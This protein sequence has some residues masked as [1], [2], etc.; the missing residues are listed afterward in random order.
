MRD[1]K[2]IC[3]GLVI[4]ALLVVSGLSNQSMAS[5]PE[6]IWPTYHG[7]M[8]RKGLNRNSTDITNPASLN[9]IWVFPRA[10]TEI[11]K[12]E[13]KYIVDN[14]NDL[15]S[16]TDDWNADHS[17][18]AWGN[19]VSS[20]TGVA[21]EDPPYSYLWALATNKSATVKAQW[22]FPPEIKS[23][24]FT[25][26][27]WVP[28]A[29]T[30]DPNN[31]QPVEYSYTRN[32]IYTVHDAQGSV[33]VAFDQTK[34]GSWQQLSTTAFDFSGSGKLYI[35]LTNKTGDT[36]ADVNSGKIRVA[37]DAIKF[38]PA[39]GQQIYSS[40]A[41]AQVFYNW[42]KVVT[43]TNGKQTTYQWSGD[44]PVVFT[45]TIEQPFMRSSGAMN[46]GAVYCINSLT[47]SN[48]DFGTN[49]DDIFTDGTRKTLTPKGQELSKELGKPLW[50]Y[51]RNFEA[52][53]D[54]EVDSFLSDAKTNDVLNIEGPVE[55]G[56]YASPAVVQATTN[57][58]KQNTKKFMCVT[59]GMDRQVYALDV[60]QG[61]NLRLLWKGPGMTL[62]EDDISTKWSV[63]PDPVTRTL[64]NDAFGGRFAW[65]LSGSGDSMVWDFGAKNL[66][67][68]RPDNIEGW[69]YNVYVWIPVSKGFENAASGNSLRTKGAS[70]KVTYNGANSA[71]VHVD[72][73]SQSNQG[74][75][76]KLG[77]YFNPEK[78]E[79]DPANSVGTNAY[80]VADAVM[81]VP[82]TIGSF[83]Y[84][85]PAVDIG[86]ALDEYDASDLAT[87]VFA[88]TA[89]Q[90]RLLCFDLSKSGSGNIPGA[91]AVSWVYPEIRTKK[92]ISNPNTNE[93]GDQPSLGQVGASPTYYVSNTGS[94]RVYL[95]TLG[96]VIHCIDPDTG[97]V[98]GT[99]TDTGE[100]DPNS[101]DSTN[102]TGGSVAGFTSSLSVGT[103]GNDISPVP[104]LFTAS[105]QGRV[106]AF[107]P[108]PANNQ[109]RLIAKFT[110]GMPLGAFRYSTPS[111]I[112]V[113]DGTSE[114]MRIWE[115]STDG[116]IYAF[117][118]S[119]TSNWH[120]S[121]P[122]VQDSTNFQ[123]PKVLAPIQAS[124]AFDADLSDPGCAKQQ[125]TMYVGDMNGTLHWF[126]ASN[127]LSNWYF[128]PDDPT[129]PDTNPLTNT[130]LQ[131]FTGFQCD[132][133]LFSS[134]NI[135]DI[136]DP[137]AASNVLSYVYVGC[138]DGR[139]YAFS[140]YGGAWGGYWA[141]G[142]WFR[143]RGGPNEYEKN[144]TT[145]LG[146]ET[147]IQVDVFQRDFWQKSADG[148]PQ[149]P[150]ILLEDPVDKKKKTYYPDP[151]DASPPSC[152]DDWIVSEGMKIGDSVKN[153]DADAYL[154][155]EAL[156]RRNNNDNKD[157]IIYQSIGNR[158]GATPIYM[159]WGETI[160]FIV[161]NL[162][163]LSSLQGGTDSQSAAGN[164]TFRLTNTSP[165]ASAGSMIAQNGVYRLKEYVVLD[166]SKPVTNPDDGKTY[167]QALTDSDG[168]TV[169]RCYAVAEVWLRPDQNPPPPGP[170]WT[171]VAEVRTT[172]K[173]SQ[174]IPIA[175]LEQTTSNGDKYYKPDYTK[176]QPFG[177][178]N[179]LAIRDDADRIDAASTPV[180][181]AWP[182]AINGQYL[183]NRALRN[184]DA[185]VHFNGNDTIVVD[186][187][188][189]EP[190]L[191][192]SAMPLVNLLYV[193]HGTSS[194]QAWLG[195]MDCSA[196]GTRVKNWEALKSDDPN[197]QQNLYRK[198]P[199]QIENF[200]IDNAELAWRG[201][202]DAI[203]NSDGYWF[204]WEFGPGS[205]DYPNI[206]RQRQ[207]FRKAS[208]D[209]LPTESNTILPPVSC[210]IYSGRSGDYAKSTMNPETVYVSADV[211]RFQ[212][213]NF[214]RAAT[215]IPT[216]ANFNGH[217]YTRTMYAYVDSIANGH[218]D[219]GDVVTGKPATYQEVYRKFAACLMV[220]P[221]K[222]IEVEEPVIDVGV[223][224][225]GLGEQLE[226]D[227]EFN[228]Y[229][230]NPAI[231]KWFKPLTIK[232]AGNVNLRNMSLGGPGVSMLSDQS[233]PTDIIGSDQLRSSLDWQAPTNLLLQQFKNWPFSS[234]GP[235]PG[236]TNLGYTLTKA[237]VG[238]PDPSELTIPDK[239]RWDMDFQSTVESARTAM[240]AEYSAAGIVNPDLSNPLRPMVSTLVPLT[241]PVGSYYS[242]FTN[243][244]FTVP[245]VPVYSLTTSSQNGNVFTSAD[246]SF[247]LKVA[248]KETQ[249]TDGV[250]STSLPNID[251]G[252]FNNKPYDVKFGDTTAAAYR[253]PASGSVYLVWS[254]NRM[255][256]PNDLQGLTNSQLA[257]LALK[258]TNAPWF[259]Y[260]GILNNVDGSWS[261]IA[262]SEKRWWQTGFWA[263]SSPAYEPAYGWPDGNGSYNLLGEFSRWDVVK[264]GN[265]DIPSV[266]HHS[267]NIV[268]FTDGDGKNRAWLT[269][270]GT[271]DVKDPTT[272]KVAQEHRVFYCDVSGGKI[273]GAPH[274]IPHNPAMVKRYPS[275]AVDK[276][277]GRL[278][279][280]WQGGS[281]GKWSL[282]AASNDAPNDE[283]K[284]TPDM[285]LL[286]PDCLTAASSPNAL[287]RR[288]WGPDATNE[289][290]LLD[291][292]YAGATKLGQTADIMLTRYAGYTRDDL[293]NLIGEGYADAYA[294][295]GK[296][297]PLPRILDEKLERD[298]RY[299]FYTSR[300]L[301]WMRP[302]KG[303]S[304]VSDDWGNPNAQMPFIR[305]VF[306]KDYEYKDEN[307][308]IVT[309]STDYAISGTDGSCWT[310][311]S[312]AGWVPVNGTMSMNI[313]P[314][315]DD[316][317]GV[318][319]YRYPENSKA[320]K[321]L[322]EMLVDYSAGVVRFTKP[323][324]EIK[325]TVT[326]KT[327]PKY[328]SYI[329]AVVR[330]D[331]TPRTWRLT[332]DKSVDNSP[333]VFLEQTDMACHT[334]P[335]LQNDSN[336]GLGLTWRTANGIPDEKN[337]PVPVDRMWVF[338]RK[339]ATG[340]QSST[341]Y[342]STYRMGVELADLFKRNRIATNPET[343]Y[344][345]SRAE[346]QVGNS[347]V[348]SHPWEID[349]SKT[350]IFFTHKDERYNAITEGG[351]SWI[352]GSL[353]NPV[354]VYYEYRT[355]QDGW[356][357]A[358]DPLEANDIFW[359]PELK[360][361]S[362]LGFSA[363]GNVNEGS[364]F[365]FADPVMLDSGPPARFRK[366]YSSKIWLFWTSTRAGSS[367]LFWETVCPEFTS[368]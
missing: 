153:K 145:S 3:F 84:S 328:G 174:Y 306:P 142:N 230:A 140:Q 93:G 237:R 104:M 259:L 336:P 78:V 45:T 312:T 76:V 22:Q 11:V 319:V 355:Q 225:H 197:Q 256:E 44:I 226:G 340:A 327:D 160:N 188:T 114:V 64:R 54:V 247:Q 267:P 215:K 28:P 27:V 121:L 275:L 180:G 341:I 258:L 358:T 102:P 301:A 234:N 283:S 15:F 5:D 367:D 47:P 170:G 260:Q 105:N 346:F 67:M 321:L 58:G 14:L 137:K 231:S 134:P 182:T 131:N 206:S 147:D 35:E 331:Y 23:G 8:L 62:S 202:E 316:G 179:P 122:L 101:G 251:S 333:K 103:T 12:E 264:W 300:H 363:D 36:E 338:W 177:V 222:K 332:T 150:G 313:V 80:V 132:G 273:P 364:I 204:P 216:A 181:V 168:K 148:K 240:A 232:N 238:D 348:F 294:P 4:L 20:A 212:P 139:I 152:G 128:N 157:S 46:T 24:Y 322:G 227:L 39:T 162:P 61:A 189:N 277:K 190:G 129:N 120:G 308:N 357:E 279:A 356:Q 208:D 41:S 311:D 349:G 352:Y 48:T 351:N 42:E 87:R 115:P 125:R 224:P 298:T 302:N 305:V 68:T 295:S 94:G 166:R 249:L 343:Q 209:G 262:D 292:V 13:Y 18:D 317:A 29:P 354:R 186:T 334:N 193:L 252:M 146:V 81:A 107:D 203:N 89:D 96:G 31:P 159:E 119:N 38:E 345:I 187:N 239:R 219:T 323:L 70:Y 155:T 83:G 304:A 92:V 191:T 201:G 192:S 173:A 360:E 205:M 217:G 299:G 265:T 32:A 56:F 223:A 112:P 117:D 136:S 50:R 51:P 169:K 310:W 342:F 244:S 248:V 59:A 293:V 7:D 196:V 242:V 185:S 344:R 91:G 289:R 34:G 110:A 158:D 138:G 106:Y 353:P 347:E 285:K 276:S 330:A 314:D 326:D 123:T 270:V 183:C 151:K 199:Y 250:T 207:D 109:L 194:R 77:T 116:K 40:P 111:C 95:P 33:Q 113:N 141:G 73:A 271:V 86:K 291:V 65:T 241:Q 274:T 297:L 288:I 63:E 361:Q 17:D 318:Y 337:G 99:Y 324:S 130:G 282:Y 55:G 161:W 269:W 144:S 126:G 49:I 365:A 165:G 171:L 329:S 53:S 263:N 156:K 261:P 307:N 214:D 286:L 43:D 235:I 195:V 287:L 254:S 178:N 88:C 30:A 284:W 280:A 257:D 290:N 167:Y 221:D 97:S 90:G 268:T 281:E 26:W 243:G 266:R 135:T 233:T 218:L 108:E 184:S 25:V 163:P 278:W 253:D 315:I 350:K 71:T 72:Q 16:A 339:A 255:L 149:Q 6:V 37:A 176:E 362:L 124:P 175:R 272:S 74:K 359:I 85:S 228:A 236:C 220:P 75:W 325:V 246:T 1:Y 309:M 229:N 19:V 69:S 133:E 82:D 164:F 172:K 79:L 296:A 60:D 127:G 21:K 213:A 2:Y 210:L 200:R 366:A 118:A 303:D 335:V 57:I 198:I 154:R 100:T 10:E 143:R 245:F 52:M 320:R 211:P 66:S 368:R 98:L 9:L